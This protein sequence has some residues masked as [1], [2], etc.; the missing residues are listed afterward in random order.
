MGWQARLAGGK[1]LVWGSDTPVGLYNNVAAGNSGPT[2]ANRGSISPSND[3]LLAKARPILI[4]AIRGIATIVERENSLI[5]L[6]LV[7]E[8]SLQQHSDFQAVLRENDEYIAT[9]HEMIDGARRVIERS[10]PPG[11]INPF[12]A[13]RTTT[14]GVQG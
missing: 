8:M 9:H 13:R 2:G 10:R 4:R 3:E 12:R 1:L 11:R 5:R 7:I 14:T 6:S